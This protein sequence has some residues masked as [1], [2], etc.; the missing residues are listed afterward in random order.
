M[1]GSENSESVEFQT[2]LEIVL[3][4]SAMLLVGYMGAHFSTVKGTDKPSGSVRTE[5]HQAASTEQPV[6]SSKASVSG[7]PTDGKA[8]RVFVPMECVPSGK[9]YT[10][11][12]EGRK[13][14]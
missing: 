12:I 3:F 4:I 13:D 1:F 7:V 9:S 5:I 8:F 14:R 11:W 10:C 2:V 6:G